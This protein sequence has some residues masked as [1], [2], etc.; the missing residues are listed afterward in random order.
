M[1]YANNTK[2]QMYIFHCVSLSSGY[3][4]NFRLA[5][6]H[7][8]RSDQKQTANASC[9]VPKTDRNR[10]EGLAQSTLGKYCR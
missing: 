4:E 5:R 2:I 1:Y 6:H 8:F 7:V 9:P 10:R 3:I